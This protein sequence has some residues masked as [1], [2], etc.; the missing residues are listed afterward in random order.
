MEL[1]IDTTSV[2]VESA[3][4]LDSANGLLAAMEEFRTIDVADEAK[5]AQAWEWLNTIAVE[6][7]QREEF[8]APMKK[9]AHEAHKV[10]TARENA[11][12]QP[13]RDAKQ[14]I[15]AGLSA[16]Q[17]EVDRLK[18]IEAAQRA[19][20]ERE[21]EDKRRLEE[22]EALEAAGEH[23]EAEAVIVAPVVHAPAPVVRKVDPRESFRETWKAEVT[24]LSQLIKAVAANP[25]LIN[26]IG[27]NQSA[28]D[29]MARAQ[30]EHL[31]ISGV[32]AVMTKTPI[33]ARR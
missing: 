29:G 15:N 27:I 16:R 20:A 4:L 10:I 9:A 3:P 8:F 5:A 24:N 14:I 11:T 33:T 1:Q 6:I 19:K 21:A 2:E 7:K 23:E 12:L 30:R 25:S 22:A 31:A 28:L 32:R 17:K 13:L 26:L 18:A